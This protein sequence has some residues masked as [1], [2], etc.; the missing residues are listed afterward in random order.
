MNPWGQTNPWYTE[1]MYL[2]I[3]IGGTKTLVA[4]LTNEGVIHESVKFPTPANYK[5][6]LAV[7]KENLGQLRTKDFRAG[8]V[9]APGE[10][11]RKR[12]IFNVG[13][14]LKW[15]DERLQHDVERITNCP[16]LL[17]NDANLAGLSEAMLLKNKH[18]KVLYLTISTGIGG[19]FIV[20]Q[21]IEPNMQDIEP[22]QIMLERGGKIVK[23]ES[24]AS[25]KAIYEKYQQ[26]ASEIEDPA[27]WKSIVK[28]WAIGFV[29]LMAVTQPDVI[30]LGGGVGHY[31]EK[32]H[33]FLIS[34]LRKY[35]TPL[36][37]IPPIIKAQR[38]EE[39]VVYGCYDLARSVYA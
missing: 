28:S 20:D 35:T 12:G 24:F 1:C 17:E 39:A 18:A 19:G 32:Y 30:V 36:V 4:A 34:E 23:W 3:D 5:D 9:A 21:K 22:G 33:D 27:T 14:N 10:I 8:T 38:P 26:Q 29:D 37:P 16:M 11:D 7:L 15:R 13:G 25:G 2:G 6:F 31:L